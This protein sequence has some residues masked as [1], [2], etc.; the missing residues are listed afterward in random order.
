MVGIRRHSS[1]P[2]AFTDKK[3]LLLSRSIITPTKLTQNVV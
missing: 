2:V 1:D 3:L